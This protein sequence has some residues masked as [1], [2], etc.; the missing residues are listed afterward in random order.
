MEHPYK[1]QVKRKRELPKEKKRYAQE[2]PHQILWDM[3]NILEYRLRTSE[4]HLST[5][6]ERVDGIEKSIGTKVGNQLEHILSGSESH[7]STI[8]ERVDGIEKSIAG[9]P[10]EH[11]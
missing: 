4:S 7:L 11:I 6:I 3:R 9:K 5:I 10:V 1:T 2:N 8:I